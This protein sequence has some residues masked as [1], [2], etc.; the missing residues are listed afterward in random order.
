MHWRCW[1][2]QNPEYWTTNVIMLSKFWTI[3]W[4]DLCKMK[5]FYLLQHLTGSQMSKTMIYV[6]RSLMLLFYVF[7]GSERIKSEKTQLNYWILS[8]WR[9]SYKRK[10]EKKKK[11]KAEV[12]LR[13]FPILPAL[14]RFQFMWLICKNITTRWHWNPASGILQT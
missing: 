10:E 4:G 13:K 12:M 8:S 11:E 9:N 5:D 3:I 1:R 6:N 14:Y 7:S 2:M